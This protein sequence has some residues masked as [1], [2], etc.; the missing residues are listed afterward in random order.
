M[1]STKITGRLR[2]YF[3]TSLWEIDPA[4]NSGFNRYRIKTMQ[5]MTL[6]VRNFWRD[7]CLLQ[8]S[9]LAFTTILSLVPFLAI[10]FA[11]LAGFGL[12]HQLEP[13]VLEQ[14]SAGSQ[15]VA[16]RIIRYIDNTSMKSLGFYGLLTLFV[17]VF[18]L[19]DNV[20]SA[21]N[22][23]WGVTETRTIRSKLGGY[24]GVIL[25]MPVLVFSAISVTTFVEN[26]DIFIWLLRTAHIGDF[27]L[28]MLHF[29]PF[30]IIWIALTC[31]Y[32][33]I[34]N[35]SVRLRPAFSGA[36]IAGTFWQIAQW[37]YIH[38]QFGFARNN[39]IYG[40]MAALPTFMLWIY[41]SWL[42]L[43]F[44]VEIVHVQQNIKNLKREIRA[45]SISF[46][47]RELL[48]LAI[49]QNV[50]TS[51]ASGNEGMTEAELGD[52]LDL[53]QKI[54]EELLRNLVATGFL[55]PVPGQPQLFTA[56]GNLQDIM[57][58]DVLTALRDSAGAWQ[59]LV[60]TEGESCLA[61]LLTKADHCSTETL[62]GISLLQI[63]GSAVAAKR[64]AAH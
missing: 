12:Q 24:I 23:I 51:L 39:A 47:V 25:S 18:M 6:V 9:A 37:G 22:A 15:E 56:V 19:L 31:V 10:L 21:F 43:L 29:V 61:E 46:R 52:I 27:F 42:I 13:L 64:R 62:A 14:L 11:I 5:F 4:A 8:A 16:G 58:A 54:L 3:S 41:V 33:I 55:R 35:T 53:P 49:L 44:G 34:P 48:T 26:Q 17:T 7:Q 30:L 32:L 28:Y 63:A 2:H 38:F 1:T 40:T 45:G 59:P 36:L 57:V 60:L 50:A 20:E